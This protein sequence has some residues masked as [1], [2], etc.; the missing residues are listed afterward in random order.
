MMRRCDVPGRTYC[1]QAEPCKNACLV[2]QNEHVARVVN[3]ATK[4]ISDDQDKT[5]ER[6][7]RARNNLAD[8]LKIASGFLRDLRTRAND[9]EDREISLRAALQVWVDA[10][11]GDAW[12]WPESGRRTALIESREALA[13]TNRVQVPDDI[14]RMNGADVRAV[15]EL[16]ADDEI[17]VRKAQEWI[18]EWVFDAIKGPL[19]PTA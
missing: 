9:S 18:S 12:I 1:G 19:P 6:L 10:E 15:L 13:K 3:D 8:K 11:G 5:I 4:L 16:L 14:F 2:H 7:I 17:T